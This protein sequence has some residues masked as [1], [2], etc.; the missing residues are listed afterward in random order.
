MVHKLIFARGYIAKQFKLKLLAYTILQPF[1]HS[2][3]VRYLW[4]DSFIEMNLVHNLYFH[5]LLT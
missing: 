2:G 3:F 4:E 1:G 5:P